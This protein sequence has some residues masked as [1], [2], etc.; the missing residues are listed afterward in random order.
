MKVLN[1]LLIISL[2]TL[3]FVHILTK[4]TLRVKEFKTNAQISKEDQNSMTCSEN[5]NAE[6]RLK[7]IQKIE[8]AID[9]ASN[10]QNRLASLTKEIE[11]KTA[12]TKSILGKDLNN[13]MILNKFIQNY[14]TP[15][16][17]FCCLGIVL[18]L[19]IS[20]IIHKTREAAWKNFNDSGNNIFSK[21]V[22]ELNFSNKCS[23]K[24]KKSFS[25]SNY[26]TKWETFEM[27]DDNS[28]NMS[29][30]EEDREY[31]RD[32]LESL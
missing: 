23:Y 26:E 21:D 29:V 9:Q 7:K 24:E 3:Q 22:S 15:L 28:L 1:T 14:Q 12:F 5:L 10:I 20:L 30:E 11:E 4:D 31:F 13:S 6:D 27:K 19:I 2:V 32:I 25:I 16:I 17:I 8:N 18:I